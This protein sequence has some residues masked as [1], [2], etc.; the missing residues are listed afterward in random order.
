M[1]SSDLAGVAFGRAD[2]HLF[3]WCKVAGSSLILT[4][5]RGV[6]Y[7]VWVGFSPRCYIM[8]VIMVTISFP[9]GDST[10]RTEIRLICGILTS[11]SQEA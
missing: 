9:D 8:A 7:R 10:A 6:S 3:F 11:F 5:I 1:C 4:D 2:H